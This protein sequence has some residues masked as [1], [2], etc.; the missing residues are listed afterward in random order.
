M[1]KF[2]RKLYKYL[3]Q[4]RIVVV[5][6][7]IFLSLALVS[8]LIKTANS[9][10]KSTNTSPSN[11]YSALFKNEGDLKQKD[12]RINIL[13][14]GTGDANHD[15]PNLTDTMIF[16]SLD[17]LYKDI[18]LLP[19]PRDI[20][21]E[22][23]KDK[24][25]SAYAY[26]ENKKAG[27]GGVL[28]KAVVSEVT[29]LPVHY[30][31]KI[32]FSAFEELIDLLEG[33]DVNVENSFTDNKFPIVGKENE[34]CPEE[35]KEFKCRYTTVSFVKGLT[36]MDGKTALNYVRSRYADGVEGTDFARSKRQ[37]NLLNSIKKKA[38]TLKNI[39]DEKLMSDL[40]S[41]VMKNIDT[42]ISKEE[43]IIFA[44]TALKF[45]DSVI[46]HGVLDW[47]DPQNNKQGLLI[48]P[49]LSKD[50]G[51]AWVLIPRNNSWKE[52]HDYIKK[53][54]TAPTPTPQ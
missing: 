13:L 36:H 5:V 27:G 40:V 25:N 17:P 19:I 28:A 48:N 31:V 21:S 44:K 11:I 12:G 23:L 51:D 38:F 32:N 43:A 29:G 47:G 53:E 46:R 35:D 6:L 42:D 26:G 14:L 49:P 37:A 33:V 4:V 1:A 3:P 7:I 24:I 2:K 9:L 39:T 22:E 20:W 52:I 34:A 8:F 54:V 30:F 10:L 50:Y 18:F 15:G 16:L 45:K 41:T